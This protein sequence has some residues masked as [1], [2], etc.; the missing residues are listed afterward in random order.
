MNSQS[1]TRSYFSRST[2][3]LT[4]AI[5]LHA[6]SISDARSVCIWRFLHCSVSWVS[7]KSRVSLRALSFWAIRSCSVLMRSGDC[8]MW[9]AR[10][11]PSL[12]SATSSS[13]R[14]AWQHTSCSHNHNSQWQRYSKNT[15]RT[16][17]TWLSEDL[18]K[19]T[20]SQ[21]YWE[22]YSHTAI[23]AQR[24]S[25]HV[26]NWSNRV[27]GLAQGSRLQHRIQACVILVKR[28]QL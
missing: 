9:L 24:L 21:L 17:S 12:L 15:A 22:A 4:A 28:P 1:D 2:C 14:L 8:T 10:R 20:S 11:V 23:N 5:S 16:Q 27:N 3:S 25:V 19:W 7:L 6:V 13:L 26:L 18:L